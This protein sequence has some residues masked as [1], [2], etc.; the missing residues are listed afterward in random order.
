[1]RSIKRELPLQHCRD[2][3]SDA[4]PAVAVYAVIFRV[5]SLRIPSSFA[6]TPLVGFVL[7]CL[8][9]TPRGPSTPILS[10]RAAALP[11]G[12]SSLR[13]AFIPELPCIL[14]PEMYAAG[15]VSLS[16]AVC[17]AAAESIP[18]SIAGSVS[19]GAPILELAEPRVDMVRPVACAQCGVS[20]PAEGPAW[21]TDALRAICAEESAR[22][23]I[24]QSGRL[25][26]M[27]HLART[28][29]AG[30]CDLLLRMVA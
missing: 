29:S 30:A 15:D 5:R 7:L 18:S 8:R 12:D 25:D 24:G 6:E 28:A 14:E 26:A 4:V 9:F 11:R 10:S 2:E 17:A 20:V 23:G 22:M 21:L 1:M 3:G 19:C 16:P 27:G 13:L